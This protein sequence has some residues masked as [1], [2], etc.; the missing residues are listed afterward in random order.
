MKKM[1][2]RTTKEQKTVARLKF[3]N[4]HPPSSIESASRHHPA[5]LC[6][7]LRRKPPAPILIA[8]GPCCP[9]GDINIV[10]AIQPLAGSASLNPGR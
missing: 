7:R 3:A 2:N 9:H 8:N 4:I 5:C 1:G 10:A 6:R